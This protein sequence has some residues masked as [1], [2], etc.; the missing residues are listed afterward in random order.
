MF[1]QLIKWE[2]TYLQERGANY[3]PPQKKKINYNIGKNSSL[4]SNS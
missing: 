2:T 3:P 1:Q 4:C